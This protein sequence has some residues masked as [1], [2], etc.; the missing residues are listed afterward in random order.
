MTK[1][2]FIPLIIALAAYAFVFDQKID[3]NGDNAIYYGIG[4]SIA[5]GNGYLSPHNGA[6]PTYPPVYPLLIAAVRACG[7]GILAVKLLNGALMLGSLALL[8]LLFR[9]ITGPVF[10]TIACLFVAVNVQMLRFST[11]GMSEIPFLFFSTGA[12]LCLLRKKYWGMILL[13]SV[14]YL[15]RSAGIALIVGI[16]AYLLCSRRWLRASAAAGIF[17]TIM[18]AWSMYLRLAGSA[19]YGGSLTAASPYN[20]DAG[21]AGLA[22]LAARALENA[23]RYLKIEIPTAFFQPVESW[24]LG[25]VLAGLIGYGLLMLPRFRAALALYL[26]ATAGMLMFWP[27][28]WTGARFLVPVIPLLVMLALWGLYEL[29]GRIVRFSPAWLCVLLV[30]MIP[31][32][33]GLRAQA[34][35]DYPR[36]W[37]E[38]FALATWC[39]HNLPPD[40]RICTR[41][42]EFVN[43]FSGR[44]TYQYDFTADR[45]ALLAGMDRAGCGYVIL[46]RLGYGQQQRFLVPAMMTKPGRFAPVVRCGDTQLLKVKGARL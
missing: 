5:A 2:I 32:L 9:E 17:G 38:Y 36:E 20:H 24:L 10:A 3:L 11:I 7:G 21:S 37:K 30:L 28:C 42:G 4:G 33:Y 41:K 19:G 27:S 39:G 14:A 45:S 44:R 15:T 35:A 40:A 23:T 22:G 16:V 26:G 8:F 46:D 12:L 1:L 43:L 31:G 18:A 29:C 25:L 6:R 13:A 34:Q